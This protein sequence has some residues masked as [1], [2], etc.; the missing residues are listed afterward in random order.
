MHRYPREIGPNNY[1]HNTYTDTGSLTLVLTEQW[2]LQ[3]LMP[4][5]KTWYFIELRP[6]LAVINVGDAL[7]FMSGKQCYSALH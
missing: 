1:G 4:E 7:R 3:V 2:R 6:G 5:I